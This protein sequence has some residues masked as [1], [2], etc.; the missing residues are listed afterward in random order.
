VYDADGAP[1]GSQAIEDVLTRYFAAH[2]M[3]AKT[4]RI[5]SASDHAPFAAA[6]IPVGG[7]FTGVG[8]RHDPCYHRACDTLANVDE[9]ALGE[10]ADA[11]AHALATFSAD[12]SG[13]RRR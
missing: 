6:G 4:R 5:G 8:A 10:M 13:V 7:L 1:E 2:G 9:A 3:P 11:A 12:V